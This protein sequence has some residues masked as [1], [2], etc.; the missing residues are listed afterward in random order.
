MRLKTLQQQP[1]W[2]IQSETYSNAIMWQKHGFYKADTL[3][4]NVNWRG[5]GSIFGCI[6]AC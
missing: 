2:E 3:H 5:N 1:T 6:L 4:H